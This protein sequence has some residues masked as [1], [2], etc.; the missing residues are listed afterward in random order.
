M[1]L[2]DLTIATMITITAAWIDPSRERGILTKLARVQP[3]IDDVE[4]AHEAILSVGKGMGTAA[5]GA[6]SL[7]KRAADL[8]ARHDQ[9]ARGIYSALTGLADL[10]D[11][12]GAALLT[13][14]DELMPAGLAI[15]GR[16]YIDE[17]GKAELV[18]RR[19]SPASRKLLKETLLGGKSLAKYV[20]AWIATARELGIVERE[21][22][23][24][25]SQTNEKPS[26]AGDALKARYEWIHC[27]YRGHSDPSAWR[28]FHRHRGWHSPPGHGR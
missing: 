27:S 6:A 1:A 3:L 4:A 26:A 10:A 11:D 13:V 24:H 22:I 16:S 5:A 15:V 23:T 18:E 25:Q 14:R 17:A 2:K 21:R 12:D 20:S 28:A 9:L 7:A 8:D 19:L